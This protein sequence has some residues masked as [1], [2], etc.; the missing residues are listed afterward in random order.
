MVRTTDSALI[1]EV[2]LTQSVLYGEVP[3]YWAGVESAAGRCDVGPL[4]Q[5]QPPFGLQWSILMCL[6]DLSCSFAFVQF[7]DIDTATRMKGRWDGK[8]IDGRSVSVQYAEDRGQR[9]PGSG[10]RGRGS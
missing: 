2:I 8:D 1:R 3:L 5:L 10:G 9:T 4:M 6:L 7:P